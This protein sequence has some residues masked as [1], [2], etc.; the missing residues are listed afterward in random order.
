MEITQKAIAKVVSAFGVQILSRKELLCTLLDDMVPEQN[1]ELQ[2]IK[3]IYTDDIGHL[4]CEALQAPY[5]D[6]EKYFKEIDNYLLNQYGLIELKRTRLLNVFRETF[7]RKTVEVKKYKDYKPALRKL[8]QEFGPYVS[9][10]VIQVFIEENK[11]FYRFSLT[12]D[13]V[14]R[15]IKNV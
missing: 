6:K 8:K 3:M 5:N 1:E 15:D 14:K 4:I 9:D 12:D 10:E 13:D 2:F 11:L 7:R